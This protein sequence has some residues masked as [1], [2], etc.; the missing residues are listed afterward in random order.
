MSN[1]L[2]HMDT[3]EALER[4]GQGDAESVIRN[5]EDPLLRWHAE[6]AL[7]DMPDPV[8]HAEDIE[9]AKDEG[10]ADM[11]QRIVE[12]LASINRDLGD[13]LDS[14]LENEKVEEQRSEL[15][16]AIDEYVI[17]EMTALIEQ[18]QND[19]AARATAT[20]K[21]PADLTPDA[22]VI[23]LAQARAAATAAGHPVMAGQ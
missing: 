19:L 16:C 20:V 10:A 1:A 6:R 2:F 4:I 12:L 9:V 7:V 21:V 5:I 22:P 14:A 17:A 15:R 13:A 3:I 23:D 11:R 8:E 18:R